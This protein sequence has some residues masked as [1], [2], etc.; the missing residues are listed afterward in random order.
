MHL[1]DHVEISTRDPRRRALPRPHRGGHP[2]EPLRSR[3]AVHRRVAEPH[4]AAQPAPDT[5]RRVDADPDLRG[6]HQVDDPLRRV[7]RARRLRDV[8]VPRPD[9]RRTTRR[10]RRVAPCLRV[11]SGSRVDGRRH[12]F[13]SRD[14]RGADRRAQHRRGR[15]RQ[16]GRGARRVRR[17]HRRSREEHHDVARL[18]RRRSCHRGRTRR[19]TRPGRRTAGYLAFTSKRG[20]KDGALDAARPA[21]RR[22]RRGPNAVHHARRP[23]RRRVVAGR[24][25][26]RLHQPH[27]RRTLR[28]QE[29][30][31]AGTTQGRA[32][33]RASQRR[34]LGLRSPEP[35]ARRGE[36]RHREATQS[37]ARRVR[38]QRDQLAARLDGDRD[39]RRN[40]TTPGTATTPATCTS[41]PS[42]SAATATP[43]GANVRPITA[44]D[45]RY[46]QPSVSP[47]GTRVAFIGAPDPDL[48]PQNAKVGILP[49]DGTTH[50]HGDI[51]W[52]STGL[53][54]T[55]Q[56]TVG[57]RAPVWESD[58]SLLA[59]AEDRG[60][61]APLPDPR[62]R[63]RRAH[64]RSPAARCR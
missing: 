22:R 35:R 42:P 6:L 39:L 43:A 56:P 40:A 45:G 14:R 12:E 23:R 64:G 63:H 27:A 1:C 61:D 26:A 29:R 50:P 20:E 24:P 9:H 17:D 36:R 57:S 8:G 7:R 5:R 44:H 28:R 55:F 10:P 2:L 48:S 38:A 11:G 25:L 19:R 53:D 41:S 60:D 34:E 30:R 4:P 13:A 51:E 3:V 59:T 37:H 16:P 21:G 46:G 62:R 18:D 54:R 31:L 33:L 32:L 49:I 58:S 52:V 15:G 47:D